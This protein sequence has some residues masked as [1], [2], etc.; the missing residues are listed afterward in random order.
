MPAHFQRVLIAMMLCRCFLFRF[1]A[2]SLIAMM[3]CHAAFR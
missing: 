3:R 2:A 1:R